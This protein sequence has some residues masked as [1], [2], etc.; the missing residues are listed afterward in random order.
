VTAT[1]LY[2]VTPET[3]EAEFLAHFGLGNVCECCGFDPD[4]ED[5]NKLYDLGWLM[6]PNELSLGIVCPMCALP[7]HRQQPELDVVQCATAEFLSL[8]ETTPVTMGPRE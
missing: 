4:E 8:D 1:T 6:N 3:T 2:E 7:D 5:D